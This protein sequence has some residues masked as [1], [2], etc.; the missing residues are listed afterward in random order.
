MGVIALPCANFTKLFGNRGTYRPRVGFI[1]TR[2]LRFLVIL[3]SGLSTVYLG[4][5]YSVQCNT[6]DSA[7]DEHAG[8]QS[9][10]IFRG[11][12]N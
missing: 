10:L 2:S 9:D 4:M 3:N 5:T 8:P 11:G 6:P 7:S 1:K 12:A